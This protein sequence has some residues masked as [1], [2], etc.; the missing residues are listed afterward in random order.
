LR[1][2][3][4]QLD[5]RDDKIVELSRLIEMSRDNDA[6]H[7]G[8]ARELRKQISDYQQRINGG[9]AAAGSPGVVADVSALYDRIRDLEDRIRSGRLRCRYCRVYYCAYYF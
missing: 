5:R 6:R 8:A 7:A 4:S 2:A 3:R 9:S 1:E